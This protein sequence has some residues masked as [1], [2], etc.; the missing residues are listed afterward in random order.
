MAPTAPEICGPCTKRKPVTDST[1]T[2]FHYVD[3]I[4]TLI[5]ELKFRNNYCIAGLFARLLAEAVLARTPAPLVIVPVPLHW[6]RYVQRGYNQSAE[7]ARELSR[8]TN[9]PMI[10]TSCERV[11]ATHPQSDLTARERRKNLKNA[12][13]ITAPLR[14]HHVAILDDVV[15]TA[16]TVN[17][18]ARTLK[19]AGVIQ[20]DVLA[21]ARA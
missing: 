10:T 4:R 13:Q 17:E 16:T 12:F 1:L 9:I 5:H 8:L 14:A 18:F 2:L 3:P 7:I 21:V 20:V 15:T 6:G 11:R 19:R